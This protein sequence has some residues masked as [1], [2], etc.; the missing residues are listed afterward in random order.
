[1]RRL[2]ISILGCSEVRWRGSGQCN[3]EDHTIYYS[4]VDNNQHPNGVAVI[5]NKN[6]SKSILGHLPISDRIM[7]LKINAAPIKLTIIQVYAPTSLSSDEDLE[8]FYIDLREAMKHTA[9]NEMTVVLGDFNAKLGKGED[10]NVIGKFG[11]GNRNERGEILAHF[12]KEHGFAVMN[13]F[14]DHHPRRL[15]TWKSPADSTQ[16]VIRNQIDFIMINKRFQNSITSCKTYPGAD[17]S[18]SHNLLLSNLKIRLKKLIPRKEKPRMKTE[19]LLIDSVKE[20]IKQELNEKLTDVNRMEDKNIEERWNTLK[21]VLTEFN[22]HEL[23]QEKRDKNKIWM[24]EEILKIMDERRKFKNK[25]NDKYKELHD[26]IRRKVKQAKEDWLNCK[27]NE[28]EELEKKHD[29]FNM[30]KKIKEGAGL[31]KKSAPN[32]ILD[33]NNQAVFDQT[34]KLDHWKKYIEQLFHSNRENLIL[35]E[36]IAHTGTSINILEI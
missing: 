1:M 20:T 24:T 36:D 2:D 16:N 27:C 29:S 10:G 9:A 8:S 14:F 18:S 13:T 19:K 23:L 6:V 26:K 11:L 17:I 32:V 35:S 15:Y 22:V 25:D 7:L 12:C 28:I 34:E 5:V 21:E 33:E 4:G 31:F 30:Y 3:I